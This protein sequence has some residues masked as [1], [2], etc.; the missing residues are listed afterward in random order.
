MAKRV[1]GAIRAAGGVLWRSI[2]NDRGGES[3]VEVAIIHRPRYDDWSLPKGKLA[4]GESEIEGAVREVW[5]E[6]GFRVRMGRPIGEIRYMKRNSFGEERPKVVRFWAMHADGG[7]FIPNNEVDELRWLPLNQASELLTHPRDREILEKFVRGPTL[8]RTVLLVRHA[9]AGS[10]AE[11]TGDDR[12]RPLDDRGRRQAEGLVRLLSRFEVV[13]IVSADFVRCVQ[14]VEPLADAIGHTI[15][16]DPL[17]SELGYPAHEDE[18]EEMIRALGTADAAAVACT[19]GDV[20]PDLLHRLAE[21]D[22]VDLPDP[23][24][25][26]KGSTWVLSFDGDRLFGA[27]YIPPP[28]IEDSVPRPTA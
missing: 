15:K 23:L 26:K 3:L 24:V 19:Q 12:I 28:R 25:Y 16:E 14:T 27:D 20:I 17:L 1:N 6:T 22:H 9:Q 21:A 5:E 18:A 13:D 11:W 4:P 8:L 2:S 7:Q 10:R